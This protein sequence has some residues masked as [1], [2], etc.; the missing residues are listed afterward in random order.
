MC[1]KTYENCVQILHDLKDLVIAI[2]NKIKAAI[3]L[4][5]T[6]TADTCPLTGKSVHDLFMN[7]ISIKGVRKAYYYYYFIHDP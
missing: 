3:L 7:I 1:H 2:G 5:M 4:K 6:C